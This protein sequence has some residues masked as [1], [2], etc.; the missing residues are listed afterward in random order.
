MNVADETKSSAMV[1][2]MVI[3]ATLKSTTDF[4]PLIKSR[5][6]KVRARTMPEI[7]RM[8]SFMERY[9]KKIDLTEKISA[10]SMALKGVT[11]NC[12]SI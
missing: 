9:C 3:A 6:I 4:L 8:S 7:I 10:R 12:P 5:I 1:V 2:A 11:L